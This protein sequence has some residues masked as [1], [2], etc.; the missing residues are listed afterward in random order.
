MLP[1]VR[2][3]NNIKSS[4]SKN[5]KE[6]TI[7]QRLDKFFGEGINSLV[8]TLSPKVI[9]VLLVNIPLDIIFRIVLFYVC[10]IL[11]LTKDNEIKV[12]LRFLAPLAGLLLSRILLFMT[13]VKINFAENPAL[14]GVYQKAFNTKSPVEIE[15]DKLFRRQYTFDNI[16]RCIVRS[17]IPPEISLWFISP[18]EHKLKVYLMINLVFKGIEIMTVLPLFVIPLI[19]RPYLPDH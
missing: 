12:P 3:P 2:K 18:G 1:R 13:L 14:C 16:L 7:S 9:K 8:L 4:K 19:I 5:S 17:L 10:L 6:L 11:M 15:N